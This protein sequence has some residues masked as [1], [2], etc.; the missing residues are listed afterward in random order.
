VYAAGCPHHTVSLSLDENG[1]SSVLNEDDY[2][3]NSTFKTRHVQKTLPR[4]SLSEAGFYN[5]TMTVET[6]YCRKIVLSIKLT[7]NDELI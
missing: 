6:D 5:L 4:V 7:V 2:Y 1:T 3:F